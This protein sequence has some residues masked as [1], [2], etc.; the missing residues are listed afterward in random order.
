MRIDTT[1]LA[2]AANEAGFIRNTYD[3]V[4][5]LTE[6]LRY[7]NEHPIMRHALALKVGTAIN[8]TVFE[9]PRLSVDIDLDF[10]SD[11]NKT[12]TA[13][14]R[15]IITADIRKYMSAEGYELSPRSRSSYTLDGAIFSYTNTAGAHDN[16]KIEINYS[17]RCHI[18]PTVCRALT[19]R[20]LGDMRVRTLD[21]REL[22][23]SK[24]KAL[25]DRATPR[26]LYDVYRM[27]DGGLMDTAEDIDALKKCSIFYMAVGNKETPLDIDATKI[28][29]MT[30]RRIKTELAP[31]LHRGERFDLPKATARVKEFLTDTMRLDDD[32]RDFL[33]E[34]SAGRY[35]PELLFDD[36]EILDRIRRHPMAEWKACGV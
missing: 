26:D 25:L 30:P 29:D 23:G 6:I 34:F 14:A 21:N 1:S 32:E 8:L 17:M 18:Y 16:I 2:N 33:R 19:V 36:A 4:L 35:R 13:D 10:C 9:M 11:A 15:E 7:I 27:L 31:V 5:R 22:F 20:S 24:I 28:D 3:K 12:E